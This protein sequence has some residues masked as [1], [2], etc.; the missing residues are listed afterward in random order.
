MSS[1]ARPRILAAADQ[2]THLLVSQALKDEFDVVPA[3]TGLDAVEKAADGDIQC[4]L[5]DLHL[6]GLDGF[7]VC[8]RLKNDPRTASIPV[9]FITRV[10]KRTDEVRGFDVGG[11]DYIRQPIHSSVIKTR[12]RTHIELARLRDRLEQLSFVDPLTGIANRPRFD[13]ALETEWRRL[14]RAGRWLSIAIVGV[15]QF[16]RFNDRLGRPAGD[17]RLRAIATSLA[18]TARRAGDLVARYGGDEFGVILPEIDPSMMQQM[19]RM[20]MAGVLSDRPADAGR[21]ADELTVSLGAVSVVPARD[22]TISG[23]LAAADRLLNEAKRAGRDRGMHL[24]LS[25]LTK[26]VIQRT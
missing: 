14:A 22:K 11:A 16:K 12:V 20:L 7:D 23:A 8:H 25:S 4:V 10:E 6:R 15:D 1:A 9:L 3:G 26:R 2:A 13:T 19:M 24:D 18:R 17:E 21:A 5:L